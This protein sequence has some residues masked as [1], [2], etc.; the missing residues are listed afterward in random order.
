[1]LIVGKTSILGKISRYEKI[2]PLLVPSFC[3]YF[4]KENY[5]KGRRFFNILQ[6][7]SFLLI[8][9]TKKYLMETIK[10]F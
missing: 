7:A 9:G 10:D 1:M 3:L 6:L 8:L 2:L 5:S 4:T